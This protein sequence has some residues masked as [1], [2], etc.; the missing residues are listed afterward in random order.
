VRNLSEPSRQMDFWHSRRVASGQHLW[1]VKVNLTAEARCLNHFDKHR[2]SR[3]L[4]ELRAVAISSLGCHSG[5]QS[6]IR[7]TARG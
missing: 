6:D 3:W 7:G 2:C 4:I 5:E 1:S